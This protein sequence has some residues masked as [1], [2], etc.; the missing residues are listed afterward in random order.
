MRILHS[1]ATLRPLD[2]SLEV[3]IAVGLARSSKDKE[4][5]DL[6]RDP[7]LPSILPES[8][9]KWFHRWGW[10]FTDSLEL[11][12]RRGAYRL[13]FRLADAI[14]GGLVNPEKIEEDTDFRLIYLACALFREQVSSSLNSAT[15]MEKH[16][17]LVTL[18]SNL[19][20]VMMNSSLATLCS[21]WRKMGS[22]NWVR[23]IQVLGNE[24]V[25]GTRW[26]VAC[27]PAVIVTL[28][29]IVALIWEGLGLSRWVA[30]SVLAFLFVAIVYAI[31]EFDLG[32]SMEWFGTLV[33]WP[34]FVAMALWFKRSKPN[35]YSHFAISFSLLTAFCLMAVMLPGHLGFRL[36]FA[37][38][39]LQA[40]F[41]GPEGS[42]IVFP[43]SWPSPATK[44]LCDALL[45]QG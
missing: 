27:A 34:S 41:A 37:L 44:K 33:F 31:K 16:Y 30:A 26:L 10:P 9:E 14:R 43:P 20:A 19:T 12:G 42:G 8:D 1:L 32:R 2:P 40:I 4:F 7:D 29:G 15:I 22:R 13:A 24:E 21:V 6:L 11:R 28:W 17:S 25:Y 18:R 35:Y 38:I 3:A 23:W 36:C 5:W 45:G 39:P